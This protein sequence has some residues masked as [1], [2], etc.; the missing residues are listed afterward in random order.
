MAATATSVAAL[1]T[2]L[3]T[4]VTP[5]VA[6]GKL[7]VGA[8]LA[9]DQLDEF[10]RVLAECS[11]QADP[12][13]D[14][15]AQVLAAMVV[16]PPPMILD[17]DDL[18][19]AMG[20]H[21]ALFLAHPDVDKVGI[22]E[23]QMRRVAATGQLLAS[24]PLAREPRRLLARHALLHNVFALHRTDLLLAWWT[25]HA[26]FHGQ[27][28][29]ARLT[30]WRAVRRVQ[31]TTRTV[32]VDELLLTDTAMPTAAALLRRSPLTLILT[33]HPSA[34]LVHWEECAFLLRDR[35]LAQALARPLLVGDDAATRLARPARLAAAFEQMLER[36]PA[37]ADVRAVAGLL[38]Y[39]AA[40]LCIDDLAT[41]K[42]DPSPL[43]A[44]AL[45]MQPRPRGLVALLALPDALAQVAPALA[46]PPGVLGAP[47]LARRW[48]AHRRQVAAQ[49]GQPVIDDIANRVSKALGKGPL[50]TPAPIPGDV[51]GAGGGQ[52]AAR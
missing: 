10:D 9:L 23:R 17:R 30:R 36:S 12:I 25:G 33:A 29:P 22:T 39:L 16:R 6:G 47:E 26:Q 5:L 40:Q 18:A 45:A 19:L 14:A 2:F 50:V 15:R 44:R 24:Q 31:Q 48:R 35:V 4:F 27:P 13:D 51:A 38:C 43:L 32:A 46:V 34:P 7:R 20:L 49:L 8:P 1:G 28:A 41:P 3:E 52:P 37:A 11:G 42:D 21:N